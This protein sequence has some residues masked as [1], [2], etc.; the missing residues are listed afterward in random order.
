MCL[1]AFN[2]CFISFAS[3]FRHLSANQLMIT[4]AY[5]RC[6]RFLQRTPYTEFLNEVNFLCVRRDG[7]RLSVDDTS[8]K[9]NKIFSS[10]A[11]SL[12]CA[13]MR[14]HFQFRWGN[15]PKENILWKFQKNL[16]PFT[17]WRKTYEN[18]FNKIVGKT[19]EMK[20][21]LLSKFGKFLLRWRTYCRQIKR[22]CL[23]LAMR[24]R[25]TTKFELNCRRMM[26]ALAGF[27]WERNDTIRCHR[28]R[29]A[30]H[31]NT[32]TTTKKLTTT[33]NGSARQ[34]TL[35][36]HEIKFNAKAFRHWTEKRRIPTF[37]WF[38][39]GKNTTFCCVLLARKTYLFELSSFRKIKVV[40]RFLFEIFRQN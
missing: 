25:H 33:S 17:F 30:A 12:S 37:N 11:T 40:C 15:Q 22:L 5:A 27:E 24:K 2:E 3:L 20:R 29:R 32:M 23:S 9:V 31:T 8:A 21:N 6:Q 16:F 1:R 4:T 38:E 35:L 36:R 39:T 14:N 7:N 28:W 13:F 26:V 10:W 34:L 19:D 18:D